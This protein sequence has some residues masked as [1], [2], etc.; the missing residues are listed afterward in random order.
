[1]TLMARKKTLILV[2]IVILAAAGVAVYYFYLAPRQ[3]EGTPV[4][5]PQDQAVAEHVQPKE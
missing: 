3:P 2:G 5:L 4:P 1:M